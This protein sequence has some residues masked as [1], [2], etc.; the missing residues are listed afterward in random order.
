MDA[1]KIHY[2][3]IYTIIDFEIA[4]IMKKEKLFKTFKIILIVK[5]EVT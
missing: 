5:F 3:N 1:N 2:I 4:P